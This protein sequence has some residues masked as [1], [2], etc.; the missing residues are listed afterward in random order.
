M[1]QQYAKASNMS[2]LLSA[3]K[4]SE[5]YPEPFR[6]Q[7]NV[8]FHVPYSEYKSYVLSLQSEMGVR[9]M[10]DLKVLSD[11]ATAD[12]PRLYNCFLMDVAFAIIK[13]L[14]Y[15]EVFKRPASII[16]PASFNDNDVSLNTFL[17]AYE[18]STGAQSQLVKIC[19]S[20][21]Y[22]LPDR[23]S[24]QNANMFKLAVVLYNIAV[25]GS[26]VKEMNLVY[27]VV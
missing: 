21:K 17:R 1:V 7:P 24:E 16:L 10:T 18:Y 15:A 9:L 2:C 12:N 11:M 8:I 25:N 13:E 19:R 22:I 3:N 5:Q 6:M 27:D 4:E 23:I 26:Q 20:R 14:S